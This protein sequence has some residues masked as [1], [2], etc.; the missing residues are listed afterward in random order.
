MA[1][2]AAFQRH[3]LLR[4][5]SLIRGACEYG[6]FYIFC[7][8]KTIDAGADTALTRKQQQALY[9]RL[10]RPFDGARF[11]LR[12]SSISI[13]GDDAG[14]TLAYVSL[15]ITDIFLMMTATE[16]QDGHFH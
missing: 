11:L 2:R 6:H 12:P 1:M 3:R 10:F 5:I 13:L 4:L 8:T 7:I 14:M 15:L 16:K 9:W